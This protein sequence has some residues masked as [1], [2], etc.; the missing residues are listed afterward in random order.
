MRR[1]S[2]V[3]AHLADDEFGVLGVNMEAER[4][5]QHAEHIAGRI[6]ALAI[7]HPRSRIGRYLTL[8][9]GV[10]TVAP[11]RALHCE[12]LVGAVQQALV[13][14]KRLGGNRVVVR[15]L[16]DAVEA[17][18]PTQFSVLDAEGSAAEPGPAQ[19]PAHFPS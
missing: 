1:A 6:R 5:A 18:A 9:G 2:D 10:V 17:E 19:E 4:A 16:E 12:A 7:H 8:S 13:E 14:A 3:I 11:S 15:A